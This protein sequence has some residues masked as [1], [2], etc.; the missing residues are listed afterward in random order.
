[1]LRC[2][3]VAAALWAALPVAQEAAIDVYTEP[4][5]PN[6]YYSDRHACPRACDSRPAEEW[7]VFS[8]FQ[9]IKFCDQPQL[10]QVGLYSTIADETTITR[11]RACTTGDAT[12]QVNALFEPIFTDP[13][14]LAEHHDE[15]LS[16][17][18]SLPDIDGGDD[19]A[20]APVL[21]E[22]QADGEDSDGAASCATGTPAKATFSVARGGAG[23]ASGALAI[24]DG[25]KT[26][27]K[28]ST[29]CRRV[30]LFGYANGTVAGA[31]VGDAFGKSSTVSSL[32]D[33]LGA[34][35]SEHTSVQLCG[36]GRNADHVLGVVIDGTGDLS[37]VQKTVRGWSEA[38]CVNNAGGSKTS[39]VDVEISE[40][41][42]PNI[43]LPDAA[44]NSTT[45]GTVLGG[46]FAAGHLAA[47]ADCRIIR[48][49]F[50]DDCGSLASRCGISG[51]DI[52]KYNTASNLCSTLKPGQPICCSSG[53]MPD[54]TP[55]PNSDG[56]CASY[57]VVENDNCSN[58]AAANG[59][60]NEQIESFNKGQNG[61]WG[62][63][64]CENL[65][66][67]MNICLS[68]GKPPMPAP[69]SNAICGP[70]KPGSEPPSGN[71]VLADLN[72]CPLNV[73]C[74]IWGQCGVNSDFCTEKRAESGNPG[75]SPPKTNGCVSNCGM[76]IKTDGKKPGSFGRIGYYE[77]W[78]FN[79]PCMTMSAA[80][81]NTDGTYTHIHWS[82]ASI[83]MTD[84]T[85]KIDDEHK[86]WSGFKGLKNIKKIISFGGWAF[87]NEQPTY[88]IL[89]QA[90]S[91]TNRETF[92]NNVVKFLKDESLDGV[93]FDWEYP[94]APDTDFPGVPSDGPNYLKFLSLIKGKLGS[95]TLS[96]AA[97]ASYWYLKQFPIKEMAKY[98][99]YIV[100]MTYDLHGQWDA[101]NKWS[102]DGCPDGNCLRSHVNLTE[103][104]QAL[105]MITKAGVSPSKI[106]VGESSYGRSFR[107]ATA[108]CD[109]PMCKYTGD[110]LNSEAMPGMCTNT[111]GYISNAEIEHIKKGYSGVKSWHDLKSNS[112]F[113]VYDKLE[114]VA[115]MT[116]MTKNTRRE[117]WKGYDFAGTID[118]AV[119]LQK[120]TNDRDEDILDDLEG[121]TRLEKCENVGKWNTLD[122]VEKNA[123]S[124]PAHCRSAHILVALQKMLSDAITGYDGLIN[125]GYDGSFKT[126]ADVVVDGAKDAVEDF[127]YEN[128]KEYFTCK[129]TE[130]KDSCKHCYA[131]DRSPDADKN[132][133]YCE[134]YD[135]GWDSIC[136]NPEVLSCSDHTYRYEE[137]DMT[138]LPD[139]SER[140]GTKPS[141]RY[142]PQTTRWAMKSGKEND[143]YADLYSAV[144]I[145]KDNIRWTDVNHY[146]CEPTESKE[147][148]RKRNWDIN[149]PV[150]SGY[151]REDVLNPKDVV[152]DAR[153]NL[154]D[155]GPSMTRV[156]DS[157]KANTFHDDLDNIVD[158]LIIPIAMVEDA[159]ANMKKVK[160][161]ADKIDK[162]KR[163]MII[164]AFLSA[165]FFFIPVM[166]AVVGAVASMA[167]VAR[168]MALL[169]TLGGAGLDIYDI[170][171]SDGNDLL[172]IFS[173]VLAPLDILSVA[174]MT[175]AAAIRRNMKADDVAKLGGAP[176]ARVEHVDRIRGVGLCKMKSARD[177]HF[178]ELPMSGLDGR[179]LNLVLSPIAFKG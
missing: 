19:D 149:F 110:R 28:Q 13:Q 20:S 47:R 144:G 12:S 158:A 69:V 42:L 48:V 152:V 155:I 154:T 137:M 106:F 37:A 104:E 176:K 31:Y 76:A 112:D 122:D 124:V 123:G 142:W 164:M 16:V 133:R 60:T 32:V 66:Y 8:S 71:E 132:C 81:A 51:S 96:I 150:P 95:K 103:T 99:D 135:C 89:R 84:W 45:N 23:S 153:K 35:A 18:S 21:G 62:W 108:G 168:I 107:M 130:T 67:G 129:V 109:G 117:K 17:L 116:D 34:D 1:M 70:T 90:M 55:K 102:A 98:L 169:G 147:D 72:P 39:D 136:D 52:T 79:R 140:S 80:N 9:R 156:L 143:F 159:V 125:G 44:S 2:L 58:L 131:A 85:V 167:N 50:G 170:V 134:N 40:L 101:G 165:I 174:K 172:A 56:T 10:F 94:G 15:I 14:E 120:F 145:D 87:S 166:G 24:L 77:S 75:T 128:G 26:Y 46:S 63:V 157:V 113:I 141:T 91:P 88:D 53:S 33:K 6:T 27:F 138:C 25:F 59:L 30:A 86:Q 64:G 74:N 146:A 151:D 78:N 163:E 97:P 41:P 115:Y 22:R 126:Y 114:W 5:D 161:L 171:K 4:A 3:S 162:Q 139:Y 83:S 54:I 100:Y 119:D 92:A 177:L 57:L 111:S 49:V 160:E 29:N 82:F 7:D 43:V 68:K 73:C 178:G 121:I 105:S 179:D 148:C 127:M 173:L 93:D 65:N 175:K 61:T 36:Q 11:I 118:W 38:K